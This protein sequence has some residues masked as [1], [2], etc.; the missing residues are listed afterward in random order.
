MVQMRYP[1][2]RCCGLKVKTE[3]RLRAPWDEQDLLALVA[4]AFTENTV[5]DVTTLPTQDLLNEGLSQLN[6]YLAPHGW[7]LDLVKDQEEIVG[8]VRRRISPDVGGVTSGELDHGR[9]RHRR[10]EGN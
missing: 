2:C 7:Q 6:V 1:T 4:A 3:E 9:K 8:V 5:A 10:K